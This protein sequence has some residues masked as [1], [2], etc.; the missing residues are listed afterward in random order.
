MIQDNNREEKPFYIGQLVVLDN[1]RSQGIFL[2]YDF[3][4]DIAYKD[5]WVWLV[6]QRDGRRSCVS[7]RHLEVVEKRDDR[8]KQQI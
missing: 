2:V 5:W 1:H 7:S 8:R 4:W 3:E 6:S